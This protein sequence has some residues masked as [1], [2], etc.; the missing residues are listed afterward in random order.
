MWREFE[1]SAATGGYDRPIDFDFPVEMPRPW[2]KLWNDIVHH[3]EV[4]SDEDAKTDLMARFAYGRGIRTLGFVNAH[5]LNSCV[6]DAQFAEDL[7]GLDILVRDGIGMRALYKLTGQV[8]GLNLNGTDLLPELFELFRG[9]RIALFGTRLELVDRVAR[10]LSVSHDAE[11]VTADG[12]Q[13]DGTYLEL[14]ERAR[15]DLVVLGMGMPKQER[16]AR[17]MK[18][19]LHQDVAIVCGG[20]I[21]DFLSGHV[22]RAPLWMRRCGLEWAH[23]LI[24]EPKRL[25]GRY[26][27]GNPLFVLRSL[28]LTLRP[29][30]G[31]SARPPRRVEVK[32]SSLSWPRIR[33][34]PDDLDHLEEVRAEL[35][36][37]PVLT[38]IKPPPTPVQAEVLRFSANRPVVARGDL[39]GRTRDLDRLVASVLEQ[40]GHALIYAPRGYGKTSLVRVFGDV[41]DSLGHV[42]I[43]ASCAKNADFAS[44][45][46]SYL[47][48]VPGLAAS[49]APL[50][51]SGVAARLAGLRDTSLVFI[52]DEFDRI[53]RDD[54]RSDIVDL[55]KDVS[56]LGAPVRFLLVGVATD[57]EQILG[58]HPSVHRCITCLPLTRLADAPIAQLLRQKAAAEGLEMKD[59]IVGSIVAV[60]AGSAYHAQLIGQHLVRT[61]AQTG[62]KAVTSADLAA[63]F[64]EV[65]DDASRIDPS[66]AGLREAFEDRRQAG[67]LIVF[68]TMA[69]ADSDDLIRFRPDDAFAGA[70]LGECRRL[71]AAGVLARAAKPGSTGVS[72][73]FVNAFTP[74]L[75]VMMQQVAELQ[76]REVETLG[77]A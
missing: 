37:R 27:I 57:A 8:G 35:P 63:V 49:D 70:A 9:R 15:P 32:P 16:V 29:A 3:V 58:Y 14:C 33:L 41:A 44:L 21:L 39:Y 69:I 48:E 22:T 19:G 61:V 43:Y 45:V 25:F 59:A 74:Q 30:R 67:H 75:L 77:R 12:F 46:G 47:E 42:V 72:Y 66:V 2:R 17:L 65:L 10:Q 4:A 71:E 11:V 76:L 52:L 73:R 31:D 36:P 56:D 50:T 68:A 40:N 6:T 18:A 54:T 13:S 26:V 60:A 20:A 38:E 64:R 5:A 28:F 24:I 53:E 23:R 7:L 51:I 62:R 55:I 34:V 1:P